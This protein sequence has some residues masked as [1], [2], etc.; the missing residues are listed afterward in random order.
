MSEKLKYSIWPK[1]KVALLFDI[2]E[3][4]TNA[5]L[6]TTVNLTFSFCLLRFSC[7]LVLQAETHY[8]PSPA[9]CLSVIGCSP[10]T[11]RMKG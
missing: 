8:P 1:M 2:V 10:L 9:L 11:C 3:E 7:L 5:F 4:K 6:S